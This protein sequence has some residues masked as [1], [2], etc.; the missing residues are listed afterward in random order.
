MD[1]RTLIRWRAKGL[2]SFGKG[3]ARLYPCPHA[4]RWVIQYRVEVQLAGECRRL[5]IELALAE[6]DAVTL[7]AGV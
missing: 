2:P 4:I 3:R 1:E 5:P 6:H 7:R